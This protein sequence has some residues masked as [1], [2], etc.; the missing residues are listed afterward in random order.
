[1]ENQFVR[2]QKQKK[3]EKLGDCKCS[4]ESLCLGLVFCGRLVSFDELINGLSVSS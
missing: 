3:E 2:Q 1:M 4:S